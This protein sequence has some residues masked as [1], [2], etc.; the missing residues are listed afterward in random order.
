M[1]AFYS[2]VGDQMVVQPQRLLPLMLALSVRYWLSTA[3]E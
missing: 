3:K 1:L 2:I